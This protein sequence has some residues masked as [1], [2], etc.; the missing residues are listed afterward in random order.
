MDSA[1]YVTNDATLALLL[2]PSLVVVYFTR[3]ASS[4]TDLPRTQ[5]DETSLHLDSKPVLSSA[6]L[7]G[8][9]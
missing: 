3:P 7:P 6:T 4:L 9:Q 5:R 2:V 8:A 1:T